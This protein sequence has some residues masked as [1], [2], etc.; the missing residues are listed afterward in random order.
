MS[1]GLGNGFGGI[2]QKAQEMQ[3]K[4]QEVQAEIADLEV[5]GESGAGLVKVRMT[6]RYDIRQVIIDDGLLSESKQV[7]EDLVAAAMNDAVRKAEQAKENKMATLTA[8]IPMPPGFKF[9][10]S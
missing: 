2:I 8:G 3:E 6:G 5:M 9:P 4:M 7:L 1:N 10:F